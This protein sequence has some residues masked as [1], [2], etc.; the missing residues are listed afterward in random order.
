[1]DEQDVKV[2]TEP[3]AEPEPLAADDTESRAPTRSSIGAVVGK[4]LP[5]LL[6]CVSAVF[7]SV[8]AVAVAGESGIDGSYIT[9][10]M[11][12]EL[13]GGIENVAV[14]NSTDVPDPLIENIRSDLESNPSD[15]VPLPAL[16]PNDYTITLTNETPYSPDMAEILN[17]PRAIPTLDELYL[18]YGEDAP[19]VL[20]L[21][22]H[23]SEA[24]ADH[25]D[26]D[27]R[28]SDKSE[29]M[30]AIGKI[31]SDRLNDAGI[32]TIHCDTVFDAEDFNMAYY[33]ASLKIRETLATYPSVSYIIDVH[34][35]SVV[36]SD[37]TYLPLTGSADGQNAAK[38]MFV[39]GTDHG[40][41][42]H[43]GWEDNLS[44]AARLQY[45]VHLEYPEIMRSIN[46]RSASFN[47]QYTKGSLILE[48]GSCANTIEEAKI[49]ADIFADA[50]ICEIIGN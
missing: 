35:D 32:N 37:G 3:Q 22:T 33:N 40:G 14:V 9:R 39:V 36:L 26:T 34:R 43:I 47:E 19:I 5:V 29:N 30:I 44:L 21:H 18:T 42:G 24:Y 13:A 41:S 23:G 7:F 50:L 38:L 1:M 27:Y 20:I 49:S 15:S 4:G 31:I 6:G 45:A 10:M 12:G 28:T 25:A 16:P 2:L 8:T 17:R 48:V 11:L 46:L